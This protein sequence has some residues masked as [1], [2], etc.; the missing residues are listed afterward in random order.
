M[1]FGLGFMWEA[2]HVIQKSSKS[3]TR[4]HAQVDMH[5][6][7]LA[8]RWRPHA[9]SHFLTY[10]QSSSQ[11]TVIFWVQ[12]SSSL[13]LKALPTPHHP[14][15]CLSFNLSFH[16]VCLFGWKSSL[17]SSSACCT[18]PI[19][20]PDSNQLVI[21]TLTVNWADYCTTCH[22]WVGGGGKTHNRVHTQGCGHNESAD[23]HYESFMAFYSSGQQSKA[24][25][26][27]YKSTQLFTHIQPFLSL[28]YSLEL[29]E[30]PGVSRPMQLL[31]GKG[32]LH[33]RA[34]ASE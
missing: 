33:Q 22:T 1:R 34:V 26:S 4:T 17:S 25:T 30:H 19:P 31:T 2:P 20:L 28:S 29:Q 6:C 12:S 18:P 5:T 15:F 16:L 27:N 14:S 24:F 32:S 11:Y 9:V 7:S 21:K 13:H 23:P 10:P 3:H 8:W